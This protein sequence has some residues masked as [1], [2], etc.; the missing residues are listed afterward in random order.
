MINELG[1]SK[2]VEEG[3]LPSA[4]FRFRIFLNYLWYKFEKNK[5]NALREW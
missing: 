4:I 1:R 5:S 2:I 3:T